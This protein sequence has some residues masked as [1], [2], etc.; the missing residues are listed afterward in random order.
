VRHK[1]CANK[2]L[3]LYRIIKMASHH[4]LLKKESPVSKEMKAALRTKQVERDCMLVIKDFFRNFGVK[5]P[6]DKVFRYANFHDF[7]PQKAIEG[8]RNGNSSPHMKLKMES[9]QSQF[10]TN[11]VF[12]LPK[13]RTWKTDSEVVYIRPS[14]FDPSE[15]EIDNL[16]ESL[17]YVFNDLSQ[18]EDQCRKG[19]AVICNMEGLNK[20]IFTTECCYKLMQ[21]LQGHMV[22]TRVK[23]LLMVNS[24]Y[25]KLWMRPMMSRKF[26]RKVH[27]IKQERLPEFLMDGFEFHLPT[28]LDQGCKIAFEVVDDYIDMKIMNEQTTSSR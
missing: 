10:E 1:L 19:V 11:T 3:F 12:P 24:P 18:T 17:C 28:E 13:V 26:A 22:P 21:T 2:A 27:L 7:H 15:M 5:L 8:I 16:I 25:K 6:D 4:I 20:K 14:R 23:L 9:L